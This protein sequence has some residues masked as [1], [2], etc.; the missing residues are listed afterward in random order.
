MP[1]IKIARAPI[2]GGILGVENTCGA[3]DGRTPASLLTYGRITT[4]DTEG[5]IGAT[6][7][8]AN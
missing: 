6:S 5:T 8:K 3:L 1:D 4:A 2:L 7:A